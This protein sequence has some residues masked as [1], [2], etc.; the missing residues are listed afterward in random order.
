MS[1]QTIGVGSSANDGTGDPA[2]T[3]FLKVNA[4]FAELY[5]IYGS[6]VEAFTFTTKQNDLAVAAGTRILRW[7]GAGTTGIT[8]I[9]APSTARVVTIVNAS[10]DYLLWLENENTASAAANRLMLPD[11]F[12]AFLMPGD[13]ITLFY[14][15][16]TARWR[17]LS[18]P[19]RG[20]AMGLAE[21]S[22]GA[23]TQALRYNSSGTGAGVVT[24]SVSAS[25]YEFGVV[26]VGTGTTATGRAG[27]GNAHNTSTVHQMVSARGP[28]LVVAK[29]QRVTANSASET[30]DAFVGF[31]NANG[32]TFTNGA[33]WVE[34]WNGSAEEW[35]MAVAD[36][37]VVAYDTTG[38]PAPSGNSLWLAVFLSSDGLQA[39]FLYSSDGLAWT[40]AARKASG[41]AS[42]INRNYTPQVEIVKSAGLTTREMRVDFLGTRYGHARRA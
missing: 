2:R 22:D 31:N 36:N 38:A 29:I 1:I 30:Y 15:L 13:T 3:A 23:E 41:I 12:P 39:D 25:A 34:R 10:T 40:L 8:G 24:V 9:A 5:G 32:G 18:W 28:A 11:G 16:T 27:V 6:E 14:D 21:F 7:N 4:N 20:Q 37:G 17:V 26:S 19:T 33:T 42:V 35:A